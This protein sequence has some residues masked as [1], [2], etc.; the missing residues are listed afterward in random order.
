M[1]LAWVT[2]QLVVTSQ[3]LA[4]TSCRL[5]PKFTFKIMVIEYLV[6]KNKSLNIIILC[7]FCLETP[8]PVIYPRMFTGTFDQ[9]SSS[10]VSLKFSHSGSD[11]VHSNF[12]VEP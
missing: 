5:S 8:G 10:I 1:V 2:G 6:Q 7:C 3:R 11:T 9:M 4:I 12:L